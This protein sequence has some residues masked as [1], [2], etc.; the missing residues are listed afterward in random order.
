[1]ESQDTNSGSNT[2]L[3]IEYL[4]MECYQNYPPIS[5]TFFH[6]WSD[7]NPN[8]FMDLQGMQSTY[9]CNIEHYSNEGL[10]YAAGHLNTARLVAVMS[11]LVKNKFYPV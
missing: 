4:Y 10:M 8:L 1:M 5:N 11:C 3:S 7:C 9:Y 2:S 6:F